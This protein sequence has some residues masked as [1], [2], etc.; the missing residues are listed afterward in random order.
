MKKTIESNRS[1]AAR[2]TIKLEILN[3]LAILQRG[4]SVTRSLPERRVITHPD[5]VLLEQRVEVLLADG[6][7]VCNIK[8]KFSHGKKDV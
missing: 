7:L 3:P 4:Y 5:Q 6:N 8:E 2:S 1:S